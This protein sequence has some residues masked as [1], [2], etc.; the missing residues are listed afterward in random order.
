MRYLLGYFGAWVIWSTYREIVDVYW[1]GDLYQLL[2]TFIVMACLVVYGNN[3]Q[4]I[5]QSLSEGPA[6]ATAIGVYLLAEFVMYL[7]ELFYSFHVKPYRLQVRVHVAT[8]PLTT[9][10]W[11][12]AIFA[13]LR[14]AIALAVAALSLEHG[15][16]NFFYSPTF[17]RLMRLRY[18]SAL[19]IDHQIERHLDFTTIVLGEL[20]FSI[21]YG[22]PAGLGVGRPTAR[23][24]LGL[25]IAFAFLIVYST[26]SGSKRT[27]HPLRRSMAGAIAWFAL[28]IPFV[29]ALTLFGDAAADIVP[30]DQAES[31]AIRWILCG[32]YSVSMLCCWG[33]GM[34]ERCE[35]R[36]GET[37]IAR[38]WR[39]LPR[40]VAAVI[41]V[42]L[43]LSPY[44]IGHSGEEISSATAAEATSAHR[45]AEAPA[46]ASA[47]EEVITA[48]L[49]N[50]GMLGIL[51]A[52]SVFL[53]LFEWLGSLD[54]PNT[55]HEEA[56]EHMRAGD[57]HTPPH[58]LRT[59]AW[60][61]FPTLFEP[62]F[63]HF[64]RSHQRQQVG[65]A[66]AEAESP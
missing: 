11:I 4:S 7:T 60:S 12:G 65:T 13:P 24:I 64:D 50:L 29:S 6:R 63:L 14:G 45:R 46:A 35:D 39:M 3:A 51:A 15:L 42:F 8:W 61:G 10:L 62:G 19:A 26:R 17:K 2:L 43:P 59:P 32:S 38:K 40:L 33:F 5:E 66:A 58:A 34:L 49:D 36:R 31:A 27:T 41:A 18:S 53:V 55:E 44:H 1:S 37:F 47:E 23:A 52:L 22:H 30:S 54:G 21:V 48:T 25:A 57:Q 20:V 56:P 16:W 9:A 28:H